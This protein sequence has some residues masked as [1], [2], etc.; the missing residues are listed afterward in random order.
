MAALAAHGLELARARPPAAEPGP[1]AQP[2]PGEPTFRVARSAS[3]P[4]EDEVVVLLSPAEEGEPVAFTV[5][6]RDVR[7]R[8]PPR[9]GGRRRRA[10]A[11]PPL[12][13]A[14]GPRRARLPRRERR[15]APPVSDSR[16]R[17]GRG[18][19][20]RFAAASNLTLLARAEGRLVV[21]KPTAGVRPLWDFAAAT[22][23]AREVLTYRVAEAMGLGSSRRRSRQRAPWVRGW[24]SASSSRDPEFDPLPLIERADEALWPVALLDLVVN[25]ADRKVGHLLA[26]AGTGRL[27]AIDHGLTFHPQPKLRT[28]LWGFAGRPFPGPCVPALEQPGG[29]PWTRAWKPRS[30]PPSAGPRPPPCGGGCAPCGGRPVHPQPPRDRHPLPW[31]PY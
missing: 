12:R 26:E 25:N 6:R 13:A 15:P 21:Y 24:C 2:P 31:P 1:P 3:A 7:R 30:P 18:L 10:P 28:V 16:R 17:G 14:P 4:K 23:A 11:V 19:V 27:W 20:G 5:A 8:R 9:P 22:L 29:S